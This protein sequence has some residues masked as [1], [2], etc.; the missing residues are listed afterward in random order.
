MIKLFIGIFIG[1]LLT[2][3]AFFKAVTKVIGQKFTVAN[4]K[5]IWELIKNE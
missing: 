4:C 3:L 5:K 2:V 1:I